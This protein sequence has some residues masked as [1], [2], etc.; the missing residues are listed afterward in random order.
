MQRVGASEAKER[1]LD[2]DNTL[3]ISVPAKKMLSGPSGEHSGTVDL[4]WGD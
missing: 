4:S 3:P 1:F 2:L